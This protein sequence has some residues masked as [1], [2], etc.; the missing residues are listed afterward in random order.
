MQEGTQQDTAIFAEWESHT[1]GIASKLLVGM[2]YT[3]GGGLGKAGHG[4]LN[5]VQV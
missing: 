1:R 5:P 4:I 2:G 3:K